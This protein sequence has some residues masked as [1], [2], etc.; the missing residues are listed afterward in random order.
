MSYHSFVSK[1]VREISIIVILI[2]CLNFPVLNVLNLFLF[3]KK[4]NYIYI[5]F[6][7]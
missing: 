2:F 1:F 4:Y 3:I 5:S 7:V 6:K